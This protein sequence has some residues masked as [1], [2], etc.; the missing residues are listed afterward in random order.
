MPLVV[1]ANI[2]APVMMMAEKIADHT[3][4]RIP[5]APSTATYY[6]RPGMHRN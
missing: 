3:R 6:S 5:L 1:T 2:N 4:G